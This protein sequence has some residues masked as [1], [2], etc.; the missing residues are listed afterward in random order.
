MYQLWIVVPY[1]TCTHSKWVH[2]CACVQMGQT[3]A[4][5]LACGLLNSVK[6]SGMP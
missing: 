4:V 1:M 2:V 3:H 6:L 5:H